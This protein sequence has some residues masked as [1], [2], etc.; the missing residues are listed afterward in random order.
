MSL[1][2]TEF[3]PQCYRPKPLAEFLS[4]DG[5]RFVRQCLPCRKRYQ[6]WSNL[7]P[8]ERRARMRT[9]PRNGI[10]YTAA[11]V[12]GSKNRK[13]GGI[14][15]SMTDMA[16]CPDACPLRDRGCYAE[17]GKVRF[18]WER[19]ATSRGESWKDFCNVVAALPEGQL[20]RHNEAGDL[21]GRGD[22]LDVR[23]LEQLVRA[24]RG[25]RGFT[26]TH[27]PLRTPARREAIR[28]ANAAGFTINLSADGLTRADE[29]AE[30]GIAPVAVVLPTDAPEK[31][32]TPAGRDVV[33]CLAE[34]KGL[35]CAEC[36]L[37]AV[38]TRRSIV[39]FRAHGQ[40]AAIVSDLVRSRRPPA[41]I[42]R[43]A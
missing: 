29:L 16:S 41:T 7:S 17:F 43:S 8:T 39:G 11:L 24:N 32:R 20:W 23:A 26:F 35:T 33:V 37:C 4:R 40:A 2:P 12:I 15:V 1:A 28:K 31:L 38:A 6:N 13:T 27:K 42:R 5:T 19:V 14:P 21:P 18:H 3:C 9:K 30:L 22:E 25:R 34:T 10:G 36:K